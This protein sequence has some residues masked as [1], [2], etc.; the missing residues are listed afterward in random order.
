MKYFLALA[1]LFFSGM[2]GAVT[3]SA[4]D[5]VS[6]YFSPDPN[7]NHKPWIEAIDSAKK[8][9]QMVIFHINQP[10]VENALIAAVNRGVN[11]EV[12]V[13][14][15]SLK[16]P[17]FLFSKKRLEKGKVKV[18]ISSAGFNIS[19]QKSIVIDSQT[20]LITSMNL[21]KSVETMRDWIVV[22]KDENIIQEMNRVFIVDVKNSQTGEAKTPEVSEP[23]LLWAPVNAETKL[24]SLIASAK[25]TISSMVENLG[26]KDIQAALIAAAKRGVEVRMISPQCGVFYTP[27][28]NVPFAKTLLEGGVKAYLM[29]NPPTIDRPYMHA[30]MLV[31]DSVKAYVGSVNFSDHSVDKAR[32]AGII[33]QNAAAVAILEREFEKDWR[34]ALSPVSALP[35]CN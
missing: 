32:E 27:Q 26:N 34:H 19:H 22:T 28:I 18:Y 35:N 31:V 30:K 20:A 2:A 6:I 24:I 5:A 29:P 15:Q 23:H 33:F 21:V 7:Q 11:V 9:I 25:K 1:M 4:E 3:S 10:D 12:I 8:T 17:P 14:R 16:L 13:D